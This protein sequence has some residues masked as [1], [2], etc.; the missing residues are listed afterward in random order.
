MR[1]SRMRTIAMITDVSEMPAFG[2]NPPM[3]RTLR[4][5]AA[6][7]LAVLLATVLTP[8]FGWEASAAQ[9]GHG[10]DMVALDDAGDAH[11]S[12]TG[13]HR[14][15]ENAHHHHGCAGHMFS[16]LMAHFGDVAA[17]TPPDLDSGLP[18]EP[19]AAVPQGF[20]E[21]LDRPPLAPALA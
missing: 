19:G 20:P 6:L 8:S 10:H 16:H 2:Y 5:I 18:A 3:R 15:D 1:I 11:D 7:L 9:G 4:H 17:F 13:G 12:H 21:R 14:G